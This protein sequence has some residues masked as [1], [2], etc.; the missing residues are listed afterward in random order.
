VVFAATDGWVV[1]VAGVIP[2]HDVSMRHKRMVMI[3]LILALPRMLFSPFIQ[4]M[5]LIMFT[6]I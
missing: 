1:A 4:Q 5:K 3:A 6:Y 2:E